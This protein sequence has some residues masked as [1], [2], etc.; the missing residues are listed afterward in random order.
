MD[1]RG[2][3]TKKNGKTIKRNAE[4]MEFLFIMALL[5]LVFLNWKA[6]VKIKDLEQRVKAMEK[7]FQEGFEIVVA[8]VKKEKDDERS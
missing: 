8:E 5:P 4:I 2:F 7:T 1:K 6:D 3:R